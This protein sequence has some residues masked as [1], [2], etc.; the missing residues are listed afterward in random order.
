MKSN[1]ESMKEELSELKERGL[2]LY[3]AMIDET[4][5]L[6]DDFKEDLKEK[7]TKLPNFNRTYDS[8]Y[9]EAL[10]V[11]K[12]LLPDR[13]DDFIKQYKQEKRKEIDFLTYGISDYL[14]GVRTTKGHQQTV[15]AD[16]SSAIGKMEMQNTILAAVSKRFE[17]KLFDIQ[18]VLQSDLFDSELEA[19]KELSNKGFIRGAGAIAGVVLEKHL[20]HVCETHSLK[21]RKKHPSISDFYQM[22]KENEIID[23]PKWRFVQHLGDLRNLCDHPKEREPTKDDALELIEGVGKVIKTVF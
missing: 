19:A 23:T 17:S 21:S 9:S 1:I 14:L 15:V 7:G 4:R 20:G 2:N 12:Q 8:W 6:P 11:I 13:V 18:E 10:V 5:G 22:L 3:L 16:K